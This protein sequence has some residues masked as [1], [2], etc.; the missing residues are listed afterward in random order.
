MALLATRLGCLDLSILALELAVLGLG[1][2]DLLQQSAL[3]VLLGHSGS[4]VLGR[5][6][7]KSANLAELWDGR[8][9]VVLLVEPLGVKN[10]S[11]LEKLQVPDQLRSQ[12][13]TRQVEP[14]RS[15][16]GLDL[17]VEG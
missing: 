12:I 17:L 6:G 3:P 9:R 7:D 2:H 13:G 14:G 5:P 10:V 4:E 11:H 16:C 8:L 1:L 15:G